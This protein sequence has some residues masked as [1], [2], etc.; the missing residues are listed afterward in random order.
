[1][2]YINNEYVDDDIYTMIAHEGYP[3]H[4]YQTVMWENSEH[5]LVRNLF[6]Y[7]GYTEGWAT[8]TEM[9]SYDISGLSPA[10][11]DLFACDTAYS[12]GVSAYIDICVNYEGWDVDDV[13][14]YLSEL[15]I[16]DA[17]VAQ[18][19]FEAVVEEPSN[20]LRYFVG[21]LCLFLL[22]LVFCFC[23]CMWIL[24]FFF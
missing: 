16:G 11:A 21:I 18:D 8:Y 5:S 2:I 20:Y 14:D 22:L 1:M 7:P 19:I 6:S 4:L 15:G 13:E 17:E 12:L 24:F 23:V 10:L 9:Y 3:G